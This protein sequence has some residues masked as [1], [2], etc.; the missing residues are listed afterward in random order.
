MV[1]VT[2]IVTDAADVIVVIIVALISSVINMHTYQVYNAENL[3]YQV[4]V[5]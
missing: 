4:A 1:G 3:S 5:C 2:V